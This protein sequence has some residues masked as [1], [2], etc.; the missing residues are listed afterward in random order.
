MQHENSCGACKNTVSAVPIFSFFETSDWRAGHTC[1]VDV[2]QVAERKNFCPRSCC[3][4][5]W[6]LAVLMLHPPLVG[7]LLFGLWW[8]S[9][10]GCRGWVSLGLCICF[11]G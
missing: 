10:V 7:W 9:Q 3:G 8:W 4:F 2:D 1:F 6:V 5:A 11:Q